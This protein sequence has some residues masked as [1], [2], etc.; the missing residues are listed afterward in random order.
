M[1][2]RYVK[3]A[4]VIIALALPAGIAAGAD[5]ASSAG[6]SAAAFLNI[7]MGARAAAMGGAFTGLADDVYALYWNPA[8]ITKLDTMQA[9][10]M[11]NSWL[12]GVSGQYIAGVYPLGYDMTV[13]ASIMTLNSGTIEGR[14]AGDNVYNYSASDS[15][16]AASIGTLL[17]DNVLVGASAKIISQNIDNESASGFGLDVGAV[18]MLS[19]GMTLGAAIQNFTLGPLK[20][21]DETGTLPM[22]IRVGI[23]FKTAAFSF[24]NPTVIVA[25]LNTPSDNSPSVGFGGE[26]WMSEVFSVR[27]GYR[28][29]MGGS[30]DIGSSGLLPAGF[31]LG[32]GLK[33]VML[34]GM[35]LGFDLAMV[36]YG[37]LGDTIR[38][39]LLIK[40]S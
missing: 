2:M 12:Q 32:C 9:T 7:P 30:N 11:Q 23:G 1:K 21:V 28:M 19:D 26:Y 40:F 38:I 24:E 22:N 10:F 27:A 25:D 36:P 33:Y 8:G 31:T 5:P 39:A 18:Y 13:G 20:F 3:Y 15:A 4:A 35:S 29:Q 34:S 14:D 37:G 17:Q 16:M 6:T